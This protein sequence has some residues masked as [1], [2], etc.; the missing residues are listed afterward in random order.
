MLALLASAAMA[1]CGGGDIATGAL[2][3]N[4]KQSSNTA[5]SSPAASSPTPSVIASKLEL[6]DA[7]GAALSTPTLSQTET[8]YLKVT[9]QNSQPYKR[10]EVSLDSTAL[11]VVTPSSRL[12]DEKGVA[13]FTIAP[14]S[15]SS[16][17]AI[18]VTAKVDTDGAQVT[19]TL[20]LQVVPASTPPVTAA[21]LEFVDAQGLALTTPNLS[22]TDARYLKI[23]AQNSQVS[24]RVE[25]SLDNALAVVTPTAKLTS[26][27]GVALFTIAPASA[28]ANGA[29][30]VTVKVD[31][32]GAQITKTLDLQVIPAAQ[33]PVVASKLELIDAQGKVLSNPGLSQTEPRSLKVTAQNSQAFKRVEI[34]L[35]NALAVVTPS[36][37]LTDEFGVALFTITPASIASNGVVKATARVNTDAAQVT[38]AMDLQVTP[39]KVS[40]TGLSATPMSVQLG[41]AITVGVNAQIDGVAAPQNSVSVAFSSSCG[42]A[43]PDVVRVDGTGKASTV[44][45]TQAAGACTVQANTTGLSA[46]L[47]AGYAVTPLPTPSAFGLKFVKADP[48]IIYMKDSVGPRTSLLTFKVFDYNGTGVAGQRVSFGFLNSKAVDFCG[49][50]GNPVG[51]TGSNGEVSVRVCSGVQPST[52]QVRATVDGSTISADSNLLTVQ[53]GLPSQRFFDLGAAQLNFYVGAGFTD[54]F[55]GLTVPITVF[56]ADRQGNPVP[57]GTPVIF[58]AEGGQINSNGQSSCIISAGRCSVDLIGQDYRPLGSRI[59]GGDPRPGR[60]TVLAM[61]DGEE[62]FIDKNDNNVYDEGVDEFEDLGRPFLDKDEDGI[63]TASYKNLQTDTLD[64]D[65]SYAMVGEAE[66]TKDCPNNTNRGLSVAN[67]CNATWN[68]S[69]VRADGRFY[70][71]TKVRRAI[72]MVFSG[73]EIAYPNSSTVPLTSACGHSAD[74]RSYDSTIPSNKR[75]ALINCARNEMKVQLADRNG[76]PLPADAA[77]KV[78]VRQTSSTGTCTASLGGSGTVVGNST[79]PTLHQILLKDCSGGEFVDLSATVKAK[80]TTFTIAVP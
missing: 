50:A 74:S 79:E 62:H 14:A 49:I 57:D 1:A 36:S 52:V 6:A 76:N 7:Q 21:K 60:V 69:G 28:S 32:D 8:R 27:N 63:F 45:Q 10:V 4:D 48:Q 17:G 12:T 65:A 5:P 37:K 35:D 61:A 13:L 54:R 40:L 44:I 66:G 67:T 47:L 24:K 64:G 68:G 53:S 30:R 19:N 56:A 78:A 80:T 70:T 15:T 2:S 59:T 46:P 42:T 31:T 43:T 77:L 38:N 41:Q 39:G 55:S 26:E 18:K 3:G 25:I 23:T 20:D 22:Q 16:N 9:A 33:T 29:V 58:V 72:V 11:A 51:S 34:S 73:G 75:T 71:P